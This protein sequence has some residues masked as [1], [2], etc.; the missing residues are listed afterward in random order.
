MTYLAM[1]GGHFGRQQERGAGRAYIGGSLAGDDVCGAV[2]GRADREW[3]AAQ[4]CD[5]PVE[6][7][8]LHRDLPLVV[9]H[10]E[11]GV[12]LPAF[13]PHEYGV[14][15]VR[16]VRRQAPRLRLPHRR[17]DDVDFLASEVAAV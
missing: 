14:R 4:D 16:P 2:R 5:P 8:Q 15:R 7:H 11:Y 12:E 13:R 3:E 9:E 10:G 1:P 6:A 17:L